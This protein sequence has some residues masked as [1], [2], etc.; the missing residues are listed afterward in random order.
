MKTIIL[1]AD[2]G[3]FELKEAIKS[4]LVSHPASQCEDLGTH[5]TESVD[6]PDIADK[7]CQA[8]QEKPDTV[9]ILCCGTGIG[10]SIRANRHDQIRA[11]C[12]YDTVTA[13]MAKAHN[14][15]NILCLGGRTTPV[16]TAIELIQTWLDTPFDG[17]RHQRRIDKLDTAIR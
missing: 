15:A 16:K 10:I 4:Y 11:A 5:S 9:G 13:T 12:V 1:G 14:N 3:G 17:G 2:H 7:V 8:I 6:Y